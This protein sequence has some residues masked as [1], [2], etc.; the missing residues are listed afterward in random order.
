MSRLS[1]L[2]L[3]PERA[4]V[5]TQKISADF[6]EAQQKELCETFI[7]MKQIFSD[8]VQQREQSFGQI[9][10]YFKRF[11]PTLK[12]PSKKRSKKKKLNQMIFLL[13]LGNFH[14]QRVVKIKNTAYIDLQKTE[15]L[16]FLNYI[17]W[18]KIIQQKICFRTFFILE[19]IV[20]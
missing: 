8:V 2:C 6:E 12:K 18:Q 15:L 19:K 20:L 13:L 1:P 11:L 3:R 14:H 7:K 17:T 5:R 9:D 10:S 4:S 16:L